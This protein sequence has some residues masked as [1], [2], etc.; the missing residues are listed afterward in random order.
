MIELQEGLRVTGAVTESVNY[1]FYRYY[2]ACK[3]FCDINIIVDP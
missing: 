3:D 1:R 2:K